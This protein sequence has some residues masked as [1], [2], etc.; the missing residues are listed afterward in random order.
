[1]DE[2][3]ELE[4]N[5]SRGVST[6]PQVPHLNIGATHDPP[7]PNKATG[8]IGSVRQIKGHSSHIDRATQKNKLLQEHNPELSSTASDTGPQRAENSPRRDSLEGRREGPEQMCAV[9]QET[10]ESSRSSGHQSTLERKSQYV[11]EV[12]H[13][14]QKQGVAESPGASSLLPGEATEQVR[15][16]RSLLEEK[17][18]GLSRSRLEE[19]ERA[20][21]EVEEREKKR[22]EREERRAAKLKADRMAAIA[23]LRKKREEK[24]VLQEKLAQ[25]EM[26][27][28]CV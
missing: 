14:Q 16:V 25:E 1:M 17:R 13:D 19:L 26:V 23:E 10:Q 27:R 21:S 8:N 15:A 12:S 18:V 20:Q 28:D 3:V 5:N 24:R 11:E 7:N 6:R 4:R 2:G 22:M 9:S